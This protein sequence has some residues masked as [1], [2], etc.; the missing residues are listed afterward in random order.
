MI[1][2]CNLSLFVSKKNESSIGKYEYITTLIAKEIS[3]L[4]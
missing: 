4:K 3:H 1:E 2:N